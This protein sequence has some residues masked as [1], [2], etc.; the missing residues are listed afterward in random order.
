MLVF[1]N[2]KPKLHDIEELGSMAE[3]YNNELLQVFPI[4]TP[5]QK[6]CFE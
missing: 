5:E 2:Y 3:N 4:A 6:E 1:S